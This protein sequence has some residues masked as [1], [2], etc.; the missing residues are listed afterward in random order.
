VPRVGEWIKFQNETVGEYFGFQVAEVT[1][2]E[3]G[4]IEIMTNLLDDVDGRGYSFE[5]EEEFDEY[6]E[7]YLEN[8]WKS[9]RGVTPNTRVSRA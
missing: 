2:R 3:S 8:G 7:S 5:D 6:Y 1:Y 9:D 4:A